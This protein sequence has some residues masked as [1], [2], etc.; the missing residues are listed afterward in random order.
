MEKQEIINQF[1]KSLVKEKIRKTKLQRLEL[2]TLYSQ[3]L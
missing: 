1:T 3:Q 2:Q